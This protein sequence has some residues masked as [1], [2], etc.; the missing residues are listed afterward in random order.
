MIAQRY[1]LSLL[2]GQRI[3]PRVLVTT[4]PYPGVKLTLRLRE[5]F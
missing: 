3:E 5:K 4:R 2:P 1:H